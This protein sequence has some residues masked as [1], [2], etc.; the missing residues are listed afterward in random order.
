MLKSHSFF[1]PFILLL[2]KLLPQNGLALR[3]IDTQA[4]LIATDFGDSDFNVITDR[5]GFSDTTGQNK[6]KTFSFA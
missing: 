4:N 6:H 2:T 3:G 5:E 1:Q